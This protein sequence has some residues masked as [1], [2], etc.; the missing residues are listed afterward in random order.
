MVRLESSLGIDEM[1][2]S[3][4]VAQTSERGS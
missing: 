2:S 1:G 3:A 4:G